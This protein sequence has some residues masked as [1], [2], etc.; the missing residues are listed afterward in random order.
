MRGLPPAGRGNAGMAP[1]FRGRRG[2]GWW[3]EGPC[4]NHGAL[5]ASCSHMTVTRNRKPVRTSYR[6][7][8]GLGSAS[9]PDI[10]P[11]ALQAAVT[12]PAN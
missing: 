8:I 9:G 1:P 7:F 4:S 5:W 3:L 6:R 11:A 12:R 10:H 2:T